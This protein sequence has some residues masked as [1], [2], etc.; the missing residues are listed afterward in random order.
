[1]RGLVVTLLALSALWAA[2]ASGYP[3]VPPRPVPSAIA[4]ATDPHAAAVVYNVA[5]LGVLDGIHLYL[6][7]SARV[8]MGSIA[9]DPVEGR[10]GGSTG[11][12][13]ANPDAFVGFSWKPGQ[14]DQVTIA[15]AT[16]TPS[17]DLTSF[18]ADSAVRYHAITSRAAVLEQIV[19]AAIR[20][21]PRIFVG[22]S[23]NVYETWI[24]YRYQRDAALGGGTAGVDQPGGLCGAQACGIENPL[25]AQVVRVQG[26]AYAPN[27][28]IGLLV[29]PID[30]LWLGASFRRGAQLS[31][32]DE[33][34]ATVR[35]APGQGLPGPVRGAASVIT[36]VPD[37]VVLGA[38]GEV[39][40][41][42]DIAA[43][44]R[45]VHYGT[46]HLRVSAQ[47]GTLASLTTHSGGALPPFEQIGRALS[48]ALSVGLG[49]RVRPRPGLR[50]APTLTFEWPAADRGAVN[51]A[52]LDAPKLDVALVLEWKPVRH[53][54]I[55]ANLG[56]TSYLF[57][58]V[59]GR[60]SGRAQVACVDARYSLDACQASYEGFG[61]P[62]SSGS[63][64][65][66]VLS[67]GLGLGL[68]Y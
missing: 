5:A 15:I 7:G 11:I 39:S 50:L 37:V 19:A 52:S 62:S 46:E 26:F 58:R 42:L 68:D 41:K 30:R 45:W 10:P 21:H 28:S 51:A 67:A 6:D 17:V 23:L 47:G 64:T 53:L 14:F 44:A 27:F 16:Y 12:S 32:D 3:F 22:A 2:P 40:S 29:R 59:S 1:M 4:G 66:F 63:Y 31:L 60:Y 38:R 56:L 36:S 43:S 20:F 25:A 18:A 35:P 61:R 8:H 24:D 54:V 9:R 34:G 57:S 48:D 55:G 65:L 13:W 33:S 49:L